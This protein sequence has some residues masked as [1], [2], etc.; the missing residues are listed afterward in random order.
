MAFIYTKTTWKLVHI[1]KV[2]LCRE[3]L[4]SIHWNKYVQILLY[5][6]GWLELHLIACQVAI[7]LSQ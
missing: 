4:D 5:F 1:S 2:I 7:D 6:T 3:K